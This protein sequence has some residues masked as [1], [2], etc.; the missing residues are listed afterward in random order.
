MQLRR[1]CEQR[2]RAMQIPRPFDLVTF[3]AHVERLRGRRLELK[4]MPGLSATAPCGM[5]LS[6]A[7]ADYV[8]YEPNTSKLHS[9]H[10]VLHEIAHMLCDHRLS[11]DASVL[12]KLL[13]SLNPAIVSRVLGRVNYATVQEQEAEML[14]T[15]IRGGRRRER[16]QDESARLTEVFDPST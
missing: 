16:S 7:D 4:P 3:C 6:L 9:E 8:L 2:V 13:P 15:L 12:T 10:I 1:R 5:W 14:A 11:M